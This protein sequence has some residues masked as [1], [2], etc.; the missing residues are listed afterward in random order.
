MPTVPDIDTLILARAKGNDWKQHALDYDPFDG[1]FGDG[2]ERTLT[3]ELRVAQRRG[4]C[5]EC[6]QAIVKGQIVRVIKKA[7]NE[8]FYGGRICEPCLD[9]IVILNR[10][11]SG[12]ESIEDPYAAFD[13][14]QALR[15][16]AVAPEASDG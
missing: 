6:A 7:D 3:D 4:T 15:H 2:S 9:A 16:G 13:A 12:D 1:D 11:L 5:R 10:G 14:R 8:G